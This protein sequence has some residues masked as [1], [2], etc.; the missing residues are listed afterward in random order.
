VQRHCFRNDK[1]STSEDSSSSKAS[2]SA[3]DNEGSGVGCYSTNERAQLKNEKRNK[4]DPFRIVE[5]IELSIYQLRS[6]ASEEVCGSIPSDVVESLEF[7][8]DAG[9][10]GCNN[11]VVEGKA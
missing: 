11:R 3:T 2:N 9:N 5:G 6:A 8:G 1:H 7:V 10:G 4:V